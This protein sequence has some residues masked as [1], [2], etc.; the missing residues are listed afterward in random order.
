MTP[1]V[2]D[3]C[4]GLGGWARG[5]LDLGWRVIGV[6]IEP[7]PYPGELIVCDVRQLD[8]RTLPPITLVVASPPC[9]AFSRWDMPWTRA[10]NPPP[11]DLSIVEACQRIARELGAPLVLENVRGAQKWLGR[12]VATYGTRYLWGDGVPA[13][14]PFAQRYR[15]NEPGAKSRL[16]SSRRRERA[17]IPYPIAR[18]VAECHLREGR[19]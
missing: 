17:I 4:C 19:R 3:L 9:E 12:S 16:S 5:F 1:T 15:K 11:P 6:D 7:L 13:L 14:V 18:W 2:L 10:K 8:V